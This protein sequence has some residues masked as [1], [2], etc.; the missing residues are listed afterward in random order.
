MRSLQDGIE[1]TLVG[2][3]LISLFL[4]ATLITL[5][6]ANLPASHLQRLLSRADHAYLY[7]AGL[8]QNWSVFAP[9]PRSNVIEFRAEVFYSNHTHR[10]WRLPRREP[11]IGA[12]VDY[13]WLK[14]VEYVLEPQ[15]DRTLWS[16]AAFYVARQMADKH[17]RPTLVRLIKREYQLRPPGHVLS[18]PRWQE[19]V[20]FSLPIGPHDLGPKA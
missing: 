8:D 18:K 2:R 14:W 19:H 11:V 5:V 6:T 3:V 17:H 15:Y 10:V 9:N 20:Y 13:R 16:P 1:R 12:Y 4:L 7:G